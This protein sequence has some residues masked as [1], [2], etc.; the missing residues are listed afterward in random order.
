M[1]EKQKENPP[2]DPKCICAREESKKFRG[3]TKSSYNNL[4]LTDF[5]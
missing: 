2:Q 4:L 5:Q 3:G 1:V